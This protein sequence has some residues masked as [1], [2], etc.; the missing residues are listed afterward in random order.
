[1]SDSNMGYMF[2][3]KYNFLTNERSEKCGY[4]SHVK[5]SIIITIIHK[6][7]GKD[8]ERKGNHSLLNF[9]NSLLFVTGTVKVWD[10][11]QKDDPVANM[12][13]VQGENRRDCWTVAFG[14]LLKSSSI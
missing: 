12:E 13:P 2:D 14:K 1:M 10:P 5:T 7:W 9:A 8:A 11:R 6:L 3:I 4:S